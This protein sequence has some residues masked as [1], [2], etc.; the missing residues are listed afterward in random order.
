MSDYA[1]LSYSLN[2][3]QGEP[4]SLVKSQ[5][6][7][8]VTTAPST[9]CM[10]AGLDDLRITPSFLKS[11]SPPELISG[12][13][14]NWDIFHYNVNTSHVNF[15]A[16]VSNNLFSLPG[17]TS[18]IS[19]AD[20]WHAIA[21]KISLREI[22]STV[23][24]YRPEHDIVLRSATTPRLPLWL[25]FYIPAYNH[26]KRVYSPVAAIIYISLHL[27]NCCSISLVNITVNLFYL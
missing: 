2:M 10:R 13:Q 14:G 21:P 17:R 25:I 4:V 16:R 5:V 1:D 19:W 3:L 9:T 18:T 23:L 27:F 8:G 7:P 6:C 24:L 12:V 26:A 15:L 11:W 22:Q 20:A